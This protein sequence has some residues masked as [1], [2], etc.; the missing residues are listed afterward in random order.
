MS[1]S[2]NKLGA[3]QVFKVAYN[4][5]LE[6]VSE[7]EKG[8]LMTE[9]HAGI[10][11]L[12]CSEAGDDQV[13]GAILNN[14]SRTYNLRFDAALHKQSVK[15]KNEIRTMIDQSIEAN[16]LLTQVDNLEDIESLV[17]KNFGL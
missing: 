4:G 2:R 11:T 14:D 12:K 13:E 3:E 5:K 8:Q 16:E 17:Q 1:D 9:N 15:R 6:P 7:E 10:E